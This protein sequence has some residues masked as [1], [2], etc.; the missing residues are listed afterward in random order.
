MGSTRIVK[1]QRV[2]SCEL[3]NALAFQWLG[4]SDA[5]DAT[6]LEVRLF[7]LAIGQ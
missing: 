7:M 1:H 2:T 6:R 4:F 3:A 5:G